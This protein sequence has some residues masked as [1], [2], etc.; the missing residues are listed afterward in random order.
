[1]QNPGKQHKEKANFPYVV[2]QE[3]EEFVNFVLSWL[4]IPNVSQGEIIKWILMFFPV[5]YSNRKNFNITLEQVASWF[6]SEEFNVF[7]LLER[8]FEEGKDFQ[9]VYQKRGLQG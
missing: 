6:G 9:I 1:M 5:L 3:C 4:E 8:N 7:R 2:S